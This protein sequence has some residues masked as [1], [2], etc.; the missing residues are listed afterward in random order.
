MFS[1][2]PVL[3]QPGSCACNELF[4]HIHMFSSMIILVQVFASA[5][6]LLDFA[7][8][9]F[10]GFALRAA[11]YASL[12]VIV[13]EEICKAEAIKK[14]NGALFS[15]EKLCKWLVQLLMA[16]DY[17]HVN[18]ILHRDVKCSNIFLTK[19][20]D[21][22]LGDFGLA[23]ML[24]SDDLASS[25]VG[26]PSYMCPELLADI[27]YGSKS[28]IWSLGCCIY[29]MTSHKPAFKAFAAELLRHPH[30]QPYVLK[31]NLKLNSPR[32]N[33]LST[34]W[35][36][37]EF[38]K[39]TR[40]AD[41][42]DV[43]V[44][45]YKEKRFSFSND[46][47]LNPSISG[48]EQDSSCSQR[49]R[50]T[51][52]YMNQRIKE[53]S[54]GSTHEGSA[55]NR[56]VVSKASNVAKTQRLT[57][58]KASVT[59]KK[60]PNFARNRESFPASR[61]PS[62]KSAHSDRRASLP[63]TT[64]AASHGYPWKPN[65]G[66]LDYIKSPDISVNAP[67]IDKM[68]EFPLASYEDPFIPTR[69]T[70]STSA[71]GSS[72]SP[73]GD[74]SIMKDKC[75]VQVRDRNFGRLSF[76]DAWQGVEG[77][78]QLE[79]EGG[80]DCSDQNATAGASSRTSSDLRRRRFDPSS[81]QQRAEALEGLLEFSARLLQ[82]EKYDELGVLLKPFGPGKVSP[83][84]TAIWLTKSIKENTIKLEDQCQG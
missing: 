2:L 20:R 10:L 16:L 61:A 17:L 46:R 37:T 4:V 68:A 23:K 57:P 3:T 15:E 34:H 44:S 27:P 81:Y 28:D 55:F 69:R 51:P 39:K 67:R 21:I 41:P 65:V 38:I 48:A 63:M 49:N 43:T 75:T 72:T 52:N 1:D 73:Q 79:R 11:M 62:R 36:E 19:D 66:I 58:T 53:L 25:V 22:R 24:T 78:I 84:E 29:E 6:S 42:E 18:H 54:V 32:R 82:E 71:Q 60:Q 13:K 74:R 40:F 33:S 80:S 64:R 8:E 14:A 56:K 76:A 59:P 50:S 70:S 12:L 5:M 9:S 47:T 26:T 35:P 7:I 45:V 83:R 31:V 30:L 77:T